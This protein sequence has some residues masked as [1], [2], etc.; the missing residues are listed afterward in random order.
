MTFFENLTMRYTQFFAYKVE[1]TLTKCDLNISVFIPAYLMTWQIHL[2]NVRVFTWE[3]AQYGLTIIECDLIF[4]DMVL[5]KK[6]TLL[7]SQKHKDCYHLENSSKGMF[8]V[9]ILVGL[10]TIKQ[11]FLSDF[12]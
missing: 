7:M 5:H 10:I 4:H 12:M 1:A 3:W 9:I 2:D 11:N 8:V 6:Y